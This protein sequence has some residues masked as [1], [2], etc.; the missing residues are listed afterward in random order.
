MH[1]VEEEEELVKKKKKV[2]SIIWTWLGFGK[3]DEQ[4]RTICK[5]CQIAVVPRGG[6]IDILEKRFCIFFCYSSFAD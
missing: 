6:N 4:E 5:S 3:T 2:P 1:G